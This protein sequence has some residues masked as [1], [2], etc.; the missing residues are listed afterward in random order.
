VPEFEL[1]RRFGIAVYLLKALPEPIL[2][3][4]KY[5]LVLLDAGL[6]ASER[7]DASDLLLASALPLSRP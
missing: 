4:R 2:Y 7:E 1:L 6:D 3:L 5:R